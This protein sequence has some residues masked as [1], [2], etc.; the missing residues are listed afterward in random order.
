MFVCKVRCPLITVWHIVHGCHAPGLQ[1]HV[2]NTAGRAALNNPDLAWQWV[3]KAGRRNLK[4]CFVACLQQN[5]NTLHG[6]LAWLHIF[7]DFT[8][9]G[10]N[11]LMIGNLFLIQRLLCWNLWFGAD[12][13][14]FLQQGSSYIKNWG[15]A[16]WNLMYKY[17]NTSSTPTLM[18]P[19]G[20]WTAYYTCY[21]TSYVLLDKSCIFRW[22]PHW[23][24][25]FPSSIGLGT[26]Y[27]PEI[28]AT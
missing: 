15:A 28:E 6:G 10:S 20:Q 21:N 12:E 17:K 11:V 22:F 19:S 7:A 27:Q 13:G 2:K 5:H 16:D 18:A 9:S 24:L 23:K 25:N 1:G 3:C 4:A 14:H 26:R 8:F